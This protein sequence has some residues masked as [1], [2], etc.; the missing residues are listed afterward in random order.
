[1]IAPISLSSANLELTE[2]VWNASANSNWNQAANWS[3]GHVPTAEECAVIAE[4]QTIEIS[5]A[6]VTGAVQCAGTLKINSGSLTVSAGHSTITGTLN[7]ASGAGVAATGEGTSLAAD[8]LVYA[9]DVNLFLD[10]LYRRRPHNRRAQR[11]R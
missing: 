1:M 8:S 9:D 6:V 11:R 7:V 4:G 10:E 2:N 5:G 3:L